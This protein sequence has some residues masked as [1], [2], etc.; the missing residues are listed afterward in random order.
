MMLTQVD[1]L[2]CILLRLIALF[3]EGEVCNVGPLR[4]SR[5]VEG[6]L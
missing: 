4:G 5:G 1:L 2:L 3:R 6:E